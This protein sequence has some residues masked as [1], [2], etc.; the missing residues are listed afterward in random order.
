[1]GILALGLLLPGCGDKGKTVKV[2]GTV[3]GPDGGPLPEAAIVI[4]QPI[5]PDGRPAQGVIYD[6]TSFSLTTYESEDGALPGKYKVIVRPAEM[7]ENDPRKAHARLVDMTAQAA[8]EP[9]R[10][11]SVIHPNYT[12]PNKTPLTQE[13]PPSG[14][15]EIH[16]N[17]D[18]T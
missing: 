14:A 15:V 8:V 10:I 16:L 1:L 3:Y 7:V 13:V 9:R 17:K 4:F 12:D 11:K 2:T 6:G 5:E 18:G